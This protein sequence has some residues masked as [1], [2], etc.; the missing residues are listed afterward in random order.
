MFMSQ[1]EVRRVIEDAILHRKV[2]SVKY[3]HA[4]DNSIVLRKKL[5]SI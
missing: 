4:E 3:Q 1:P 2:L 5:R